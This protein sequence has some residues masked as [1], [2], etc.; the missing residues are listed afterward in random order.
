M[1]AVRRGARARRSRLSRNIYFL[2]SLQSANTL[3]RAALPHRLPAALP[4]TVPCRQCACVYAASPPRLLLNA[5]EGATGAFCPWSRFGTCERSGVR[6][7]LSKPKEKDGGCRP[8]LLVGMRWTAYSKSAH[9]SIPL[10]NLKSPYFMQ[11][12]V[13]FQSA[14]KNRKI[15][16]FR[17]FVYDSCTETAADESAAAAFSPNLCTDIEC[18][19]KRLL[20]LLACVRQRVIDRLF[21]ILRL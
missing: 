2:A 5:A 4:T 18:L 21:Q 9:F 17:K 7:A 15:Q 11:I 8:F 1:R 14:R 12:F 10:Q 16:I 20:D 3:A 6:P 19:V 13:V